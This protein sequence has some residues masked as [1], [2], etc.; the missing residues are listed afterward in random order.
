MASNERDFWAG[1]A[2]GGTAAIGPS[3]ASA[4]RALREPRIDTPALNIYLGSTPAQ[5]GL[6]L[7]KYE[8]RDLLPQDRRRIASLYLDIDAP[9]P[10][11]TELATWRQGSD[12]WARVEIKHIEVP[13]DVEY[14]SLNKQQVQHLLIEPHLPRSY[15]HGAGGIRNNGH[16]ALSANVDEIATRIEQLLSALVS[17]G[18]ERTERRAR[19]IL[20]NIVAFLGGGTG[21]GTLPDMAVLVRNILRRNGYPARV[22]I[23][24]LLPEHIGSATPQEISWRR[25]NMVATLEELMALSIVGHTTSRYQKLVGGLPL[26]IE[27]EPVANEIFL[28]GRTEMSS[29]AQVAQIAG[30]DMFMRLCDRSG[31]GRHERSLQSDLQCLVQRDDRNLYTMFG[32]SCPMEVVLP[33]RELAEAFAY[34]SAGTLISDLTS[35]G[36]ASTPT[37]ARHAAARAEETTATLRSDL[38][39][40]YLKRA[41]PW[42]EALRPEFQ[43]LPAGPFERART[44]RALDVLWEAMEDRVDRAAGEMEDARDAL[45]AEEEAAIDSTVPPNAT[46]GVGPLALWRMLLEERLRLYQ[47]ALREETDGARGAPPRDTQVEATLI[48]ARLPLGQAGRVRAVHEAYNRQL[49]AR[50][51]IERRRL[52][53]DL[54]RQLC[55]RVESRLSQLQS[56]VPELS[57]SAT[58]DYLASR[59]QSYPE[60]SGRLTRAHPHRTNVFDLDE[61][62]TNGHSWPTER[63][64]EHL[65]NSAAADRDSSGQNPHIGRFLEWAIKTHGPLALSPRQSAQ[66][67][68]ERV[69][70]YFRDVVYLPALQRTTLLHAVAD[71]CKEAGDRSGDRAIETVVTAHLGRMKEHVQPLIKHNPGVWEGGTQLLRP[72]ASLG[73]SME[74]HQRELVQR[75][76][77]QVGGVGQSGQAIRPAVQD[78]LDPH[79]IQLLYAQHGFSLTSV[80]DFYAEENSAMADYKYHQ[81]RWDGTGHDGSYGQGGLPVFTSREAERLVKDGRALGDPQGRDLIERTVRDPFKWRTDGA[82]QN[83]HHG[84]NGSSGAS[85][86]SGAGAGGLG[87]IIGQGAFRRGVNN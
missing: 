16:V 52:T 20:V 29:P 74:P 87:G 36:R 24:C 14:N 1:G 58:Q 79:R 25:S 45:L 63:L 80:G 38:R 27:A 33:A 8:L 64:Y 7:D 17:Y 6:W 2:G 70:E 82:A 56:F 31:V 40:R 41:K 21:S 35:Y 57:S 78:S 42:R 62:R 32:T 59:E 53:V 5:A 69:V 46:G 10:E 39:Q 11:L 55:D 26:D 28:F 30:M 9:P 77:N 47:A 12:G 51:E 73:L 15:S 68:A 48:S 3:D 67:F 71:F 65:H 13:L 19:D 43:R 22:F 23:Y 83:G 60:L 37:G 72:T 75:I 86:S 85:G 4:P 49:T 18:G 76:V 34:R 66:Q 54:L 81:H 61:L 84:S 44:Q 50:V